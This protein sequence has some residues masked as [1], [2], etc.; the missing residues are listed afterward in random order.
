M[1]VA[2]EHSGQRYFCLLRKL[3]HNAPHSVST[4]QAVAGVEKKDILP[5]GSLQRFVHRVVKS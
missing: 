1:G 3:L 2:I 4:V 5:R